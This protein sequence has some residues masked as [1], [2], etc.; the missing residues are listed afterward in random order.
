MQ[1]AKRPMSTRLWPPPSAR[2][3]RSHGPAATSESSCWKASSQHTR[4]TMTRWLPRSPTRWA[5]RSHSPGTH[6]RPPASGI[7]PTSLSVLRTFEFDEI[8]N[9][10]LI[11]REPIG[12]CGFITPWNWPDEPDRLQGR[13]R[14]GRRLHDGAEAER[15]RAA[16]GAFSSPRSCTRPACRPACST[17]SMATARRSAQRYRAHPDVDMVSFTGSTRAGIA[18]AQGGRRHGQARRAGT[19]RKIAEHHSD[20]CGLRSAPSTHGVTLLQQQRPVVQRPDAHAGAAHDRQDEVIDIAR[21]IAEQT[22]VGDPPSSGD[23]PRAG[24]QQGAV[25][26]DPGAIEAASPKARDWSPADPDGPRASNRGYYRPARRS[27]RRAQ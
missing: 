18:V 17:W 3:R 15:I 16:V 10:A 13:A 12:V 14:A 20:G 26:Q 2:F 11:T 9:N 21:Q 8:I 7:S 19:R 23:R 5:L 6:R 4:S 22:A 27:S 25:R 24:G 1:W